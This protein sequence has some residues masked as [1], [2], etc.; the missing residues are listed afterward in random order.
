[1]GQIAE[2]VFNFL[3]DVAGKVATAS[4]FIG[5][6]FNTVTAIMREI[7]AVTATTVQYLLE[8]GAHIVE[9]YAIGPSEIAAQMRLA[10][11]S[12]QMEAVD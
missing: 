7:N 10:A 6:A 2:T 5:V 9:F 1:M 11:E 4:D 8:M 3:I 12:F